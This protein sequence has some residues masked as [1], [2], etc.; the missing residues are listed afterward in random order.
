MF[1]SS[2]TPRYIICVHPLVSMFLFAGVSLQGQERRVYGLVS[3]RVSTVCRLI[4]PVTLSSIMEVLH[5][6][7][8]GRVAVHVEVS[9]EI[10]ARK[11][12]S[13][14]Q[15]TRSYPVETGVCLVGLLE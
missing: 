14:I 10:L 7:D 6:G 1:S 13:F 3:S 12:S 8:V 15:Q 9:P 5:G 2:A 11:Y 4:P